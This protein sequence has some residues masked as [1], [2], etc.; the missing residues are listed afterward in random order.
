MIYT[1]RDNLTV[2]SIDEERE[3]GFDVLANLLMER[4]SNMIYIEK[5]DKL[6]GIVS[7]GDIRRA[8]EKGKR[9]V[10]IN[11]SFAFFRGFEYIR[12]REL[13][14][15]N[16]KINSVPIVNSFNELI[17]DY[18]RWDDYC[19][20]YELLFLKSEHFKSFFEEKSGGISFV[21]PTSTSNTKY[22]LLEK[23][24]KI[25]DEI[26]LKTIVINKKDLV[27]AFRNSD[28]V[29]FSDEDELRGLRT[30]F[31]DVLEQDFVDE[32]AF[33]FKNLGE[34]IEKKIGESEAEAISKEI[35][36]RIIKKVEDRGVHIITVNI[37]HTDNNYWQKLEKGFEK[38]FAKIGK[39]RQDILY[40]EFWEDFYC[41][42]YS[43]NYSKLA[44]MQ[45]IL[46]CI[47]DSIIMLKDSDTETYNVING[48]RLTVG[49]PREYERTIY[50]LGPCL[51][52]GIKVDDSRTIESYL[53]NILNLEK[54]PCRV[55]NYGS[56]QNG[57][58]LL[59]R[60]CSIKFKNGD[61]VILYYDSIY[62]IP[63]INLA[64]CIEYNDLPVEW[65]CESVYHCN[66][67][68]NEIFANEIYNNIPKEW[69]NF[70]TSTEIDRVE[71][72]YDEIV[73]AYINRYFQ[74]D[75]PEGQIGAIVMNCN[76]YTKG[77]RYLIEEAARRVDHLIV[78][79]V[80]ENKSLFT[81]ME[82]F[83][84]VVEGTR[85][86][87]NI[88]VVPSGD[89]ILSQMTFPEYFVKRDDEEVSRNAEFDI[90]LFAEKIAP[91][92]GIKYRFVGEEK[93]DIVTNKYNQAMKKI[94]PE[95]GIDLY[96]IPRKTTDEGVIISATAVRELLNKG[97]NSGI[98]EYVPQSTIDILFS[99]W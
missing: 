98:E 68:V 57:L 11:C 96:E 9:A 12:A 2:F 91:K 27:E 21:A 30:L 97:D 35:G 26:G 89:Y 69:F 75:K 47:R 7:M 5:N 60:L 92:L 73:D 58:Q 4:P 65:F 28:L 49:Q 83:A 42:I 3:I 88:S 71:I 62:D 64:D 41:D 25:F 13:F 23:Y 15:K 17:G 16:R 6:Y 93:D 74:S 54:I 40:E 55:V 32:K 10:T 53:Q 95:N 31:L 20:G 45:P 87:K 1:D 37:T 46:P 38:K 84:M 70:N 59:Q 44:S 43:Y 94:L 80:E 33:T 82:R 78:F 24:R 34:E 61:I 36:E 18:S 39:K 72:P 99:S 63:S 77:H 67:K 8:K 56:W 14:Q 85:D 79:V 29:L 48:E 86:I 19:S 81:F 66:H 50:F 51:I 90:R 76:P 22:N 52:I